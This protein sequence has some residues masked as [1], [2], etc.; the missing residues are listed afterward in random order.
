MSNMPR[1]VIAAVGGL[2]ATWERNV[3][4]RLAGYVTRWPVL[5]IALWLVVPAALLAARP[6]LSE[7]MKQHPVAMVPAD[8]PAMATAAQMTDAFHE[9][10]QDNLL[11][12]VLTDDGGLNPADEDTYRA[13]V[14][15][16]RSDDHDVK[17]LQEFVSTPQLRD[18]VTSKDHKAW[19]LPVGLAGELDT[20]LGNEAYQHVTETVQR[21]AGGSALKV[22][23]TGPSAT[24]ADIT[25]VGDRDMHN[26]EIATAVLVL[27]ILLVIY[28][29]PMTMMLPLMT[30][31]AS[32]MTARGVVSGLAQIGLGDVQRDRDPDD[33]DDRR[34]RNGLRRLPDQ[35]L[36]RAPAHGNGLRHRRRLGATVHRQGDR[37]VGGD[38]GHHLLM[39][40]LRQARAAVHR[41][42]RAGHHGLHRHAGRVHAAARHPGARGPSRLGQ[43]PP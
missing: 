39:H 24:I 11:L 34:G 43:A 5:V 6:P 12:V 4:E 17:M 3:F 40:E 20:P 23:V 35:S 8:A 25:S 31:G 32:L 15:A 1:K 10:G 30:I 41:R 33:R 9:S 26:I 13:L 2:T 16:L 42:A 37:G 28:R 27:L 19:I 7:A 14:V 38:G 22:N 36:P 29:N 18:V 21:V